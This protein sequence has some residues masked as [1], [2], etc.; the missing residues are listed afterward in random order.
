MSRKSVAVSGS[1]KEPDYGL[2]KV[3]HR[4][5][6]ESLDDLVEV[7]PK[8]RI[9]NFSIEATGSGSSIYVKIGNPRSASM[10]LETRG[11]DLDPSFE[12]IVK[13]LRR[14][15]KR[16]QSF[17]YLGVMFGPVAAV[18]TPLT[19]LD[20]VGNL[21]L[22]Y[23]SSRPPHNLSVAVA[24]AMVALLVL[25]P[26]SL[27]VW[28]WATSTSVRLKPRL[29]ASSLTANIRAISRRPFSRLGNLYRADGLIEQK[30]LFATI[31]SM[32]VA[33]GSL[34]IALLAWVF[35]RN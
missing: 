16:S 32:L 20:Q 34:I 6:A 26:V 19:I 31:T 5:E 4:W 23:D 17:H 13:V 7:A 30:M 10:V 27:A 2:Y 15:E 22:F 11:D 9:F 24:L 3:S 1:S 28:A 12:E 35:P 25:L 8:G 14:A 33:I 29:D 18:L 21:G